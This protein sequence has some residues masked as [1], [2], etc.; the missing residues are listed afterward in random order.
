MHNI[1]FEPACMDDR[2]RWLL[3]FLCLCTYS[4]CQETQ[5]AFG[6]S[7]NDRYTVIG[8]VH[9]GISLCHYFFS[10]DNE[11]ERRSISF[12]RPAVKRKAPK[13]MYPMADR[14][15]FYTRQSLFHLHHMKLLPSQQIKYFA[16]FGYFSLFRNQIPGTFFIWLLQRLNWG[17]FFFILC[18]KAS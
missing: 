11:K 13:R 2:C 10:L 8:N 9:S 12:R 5:M 15:T 16:E 17:V 6:K 14:L 18:T 3:M 4:A 1:I 7:W